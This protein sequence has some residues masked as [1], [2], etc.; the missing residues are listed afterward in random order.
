MTD[1][2]QALL[3]SC[4]AASPSLVTHQ[5]SPK[6]AFAAHLHLP[7]AHIPAHVQPAV[8]ELRLRPLQGDIPNE[9]GGWPV[10]NDAVAAAEKDRVKQRGKTQAGS[11]NGCD[12]ASATRL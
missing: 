7:A 10:E 8:V 2:N 4:V 1:T 9:V 3:P 12:A 11:S 5:V 6:P